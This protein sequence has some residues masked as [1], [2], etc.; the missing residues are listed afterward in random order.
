MTLGSK[1][2]LGSGASSLTLKLGAVLPSM[3][4]LLQLVTPSVAEGPLFVRGE[5]RSL[6]FARDDGLAATLL[7]RR[8][9]AETIGQRTQVARLLCHG[10]GELL[11]CRHDRLDVHCAQAGST[12]IDEEEIGKRLLDPLGDLRRQALRRHDAVP[13]DGVE[14][15]YAQ[16]LEGR[17]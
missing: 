9:D 8:L 17:H 7:I 4:F 1:L 3:V 16:A 5:K 11:G 15:F 14:T 10:L 6:D 13:E 12:W 2:T